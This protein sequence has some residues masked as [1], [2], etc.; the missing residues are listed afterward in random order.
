MIGMSLRLQQPSAG[1]FDT[2]Q[3]LLEDKRMNCD[4]ASLD[5]YLM[6]L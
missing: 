3:K 1:S 2:Y 6:L 4:F 5:Q